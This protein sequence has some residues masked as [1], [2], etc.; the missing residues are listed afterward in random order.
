MVT[1]VRAGDGE[2]EVDEHA[3]VQGEGIDRF[4]IDDCADAGILGLQQ[5]ARGFHADALLVA[6]E[7]E[8]EIDGGLLTD[9]ER[10]GVFGLGKALAIDGKGVGSGLKAGDFV[11]ASRIGDDFSICSGGGVAGVDVCS[12]YGMVL[13]IEHRTANDSIVALCGSGGD[14][15]D[16]AERCQKLFAQLGSPKNERNRT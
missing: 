10:D 11:E 14:A 16:E 13:G 12:G 8:F 4:L 7:V 2:D 5:F 1:E 15:Y 3:A 6:A 9:F